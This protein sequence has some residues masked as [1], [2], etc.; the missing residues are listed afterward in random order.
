MESRQWYTDTLGIPLV[1]FTDAPPAPSLKQLHDNK[2][3]ILRNIY[4]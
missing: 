4:K 2:V 3:F 1:L